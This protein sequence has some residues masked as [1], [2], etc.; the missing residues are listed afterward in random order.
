MP[1]AIVYHYKLV[2]LTGF[3]YEHILSL[4]SVAD[5]LKLNEDDTLNNFLLLR[6]YPLVL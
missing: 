6:T 2:D 3:P 5:F 4:V 1:K